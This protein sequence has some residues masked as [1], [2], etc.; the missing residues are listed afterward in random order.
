MGL[1]EQM[2][3]RNMQETYNPQKVELLQNRMNT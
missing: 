1:F 2:A 3:Q